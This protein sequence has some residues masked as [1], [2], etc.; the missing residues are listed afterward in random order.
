[1]LFSTTQAQKKYTL[2][3]P[4]VVEDTRTDSINW[5]ISREPIAQIV[6]DAISQ[7]KA[8]NVAV[9][10]RD[11][12]NGPSFGVNENEPFAP[13]SLLKIPTMITLLKMADQD[14]NVLTEK[15]SLLVESAQAREQT[16]PPNNQLDPNSQYTLK[17][18]LEQM[19]IYSDNEA[20]NTILEYVGTQKVIEVRE[21]LGLP[22]PEFREGFNFLSAREYSR[23]FRVLYEGS[24]L[25]L[26][27][28]QYALELLTK[29]EFDLGLSLGT[30]NS[31]LLA[32]K[33]GI[34][35]LDSQTER[36]LHDCGIFYH[37]QTHYILCVM[38][39]GSNL[40]ELSKIITQISENIFL[41]H[42]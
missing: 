25:S 16:Y 15:R 8:S 9:Y 5:S 1:M 40:D 6:S 34:F 37:S 32:D 36:Q 4:F 10:Y 12:E 20:F 21:D 23:L 22:V 3:S 39:K 26:E 30:K 17:Q 11:L 7:Q 13:A 18:L 31:V 33:F 29:T 19:I 27:N 35:S 28:S 38:T 14:P 41:Q 2:L 24:Y 42:Q